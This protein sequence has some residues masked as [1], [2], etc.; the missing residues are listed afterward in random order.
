MSQN[1]MSRRVRVSDI[2]TV[3]IFA[4]PLASTVL[5]LGISIR[6]GGRALILFSDKYYPL[7]SFF[8]VGIG[9]LI[10]KEMDV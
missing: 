8:I 1:E 5:K 4:F 7:G 10:T 9:Y 3:W 2:G 6:R